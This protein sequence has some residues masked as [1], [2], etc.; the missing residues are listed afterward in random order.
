MVMFSLFLPLQDGSRN[1][2]AIGQ[3]ARPGQTFIYG[4]QKTGRFI[5][6]VN[7]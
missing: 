7:N 4:E 1:V 6:V 2:G 5:L 3:Y